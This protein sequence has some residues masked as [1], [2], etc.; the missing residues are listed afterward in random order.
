MQSTNTNWSLIYTLSWLATTMV[1]DQLWSILDD[2][3]CFINYRGCALYLYWYEWFSNS[4]CPKKY[5]RSRSKDSSLWKKKVFLNYEYKCSRLVS[6]SLYGVS[7]LIK[8]HILLPYLLYIV[9]TVI[10]ETLDEWIAGRSH[11]S[12][13]W[14]LSF[15][16]LNF[17][18]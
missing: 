8:G 12:P 4:F 14:N 13:R 5:E 6:Q 7:M 15:R 17:K 11:F 1:L 9:Y 10:N 18:I 2:G 3:Y 16:E